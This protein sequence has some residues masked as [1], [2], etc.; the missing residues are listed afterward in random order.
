MPLII[1]M[2][3]IMVTTIS[4][5]KNKKMNLNWQLLRVSQF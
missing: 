1:I 5:W 4:S 2:I 3:V